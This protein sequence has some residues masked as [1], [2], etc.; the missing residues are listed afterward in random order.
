[1]LWV[2][3]FTMVSARE[4]CHFELA[5]RFRLLDIMD[6]GGRW[7]EWRS[8]TICC[9]SQGTETTVALDAY[10]RSCCQIVKETIRQHVDATKGAR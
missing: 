9:I 2:V 5:F 1:M 6:G 3:P 10:S 7:S 4:D 8:Q